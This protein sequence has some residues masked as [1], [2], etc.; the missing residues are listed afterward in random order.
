MNKVEVMN[1]VE[2]LKYI[3]KQLIDNGWDGWS[4]L[5]SGEFVSPDSNFKVD[6]TYDCTNESFIVKVAMLCTFDR[7]ANSGI[8]KYFNTKEDVLKF[9][10]GEYIVE[11][12]SEIVELMSSNIEFNEN[13][14]YALNE[15]TY[16]LVNNMIGMIDDW[17]HDED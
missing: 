7:W 17:F 1:K 15:R 3:T 5:G 6:V 2:D 16:T 10:D 11:A 14:K 4:D 13:G 9:L 12:F 8:C